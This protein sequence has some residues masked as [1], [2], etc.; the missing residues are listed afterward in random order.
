VFSPVVIAT[1][2][3]NDGRI[4][5]YWVSRFEVGH[6]RTYLGNR[7]TEFITEDDRWCHPRQRMWV[8]GSWNES[9]SI[10][11][12]VEVCST[13]ASGLDVDMYSVDHIGF[14]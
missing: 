6:I 2:V 5:C 13:D 12:L 1:F 9:R 11:I 14:E 7:P 3:T 8:V 4:H 10:R